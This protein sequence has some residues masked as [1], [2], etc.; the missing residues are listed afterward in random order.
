MSVFTKDDY[1]SGDGMLTAIWGP[2]MWHTLHTISF[3]YPVKPSKEQKDNY[4]QYFL[5]LQHIL[6]CKY[7]RENLKK[8]LKN[9]PLQL[10]DMKNRETYSRF[11]YELHERINSQL[12]KTS[13]L[14]YC[15]V[16]ERYEH[17]RSRCI[18]TK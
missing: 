13:G 4:Y 14:S 15:D 9:K 12:G 16:R 8:N 11:I 5:T 6:P 3:N 18:E 2:P 7:C 17:F 10:C 1:N